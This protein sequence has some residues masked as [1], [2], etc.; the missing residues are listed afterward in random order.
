MNHRQYGRFSGGVQLS[1]SHVFSSCTIWLVSNIC[2][3]LHALERSLWHASRQHISLLVPTR[4]KRPQSNGRSW[5]LASGGGLVFGLLD[6]LA[7]AEAHA[8]VAWAR[9][10]RPCNRR[11]RRPLAF[12]ARSRTV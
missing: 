9:R 6:G 8:P 5:C 7:V 12:S 3:P 1:R 10:S 11:G 2:K 4:W